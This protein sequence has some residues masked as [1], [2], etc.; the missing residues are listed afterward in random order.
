MGLSDVNLHFYSADER[1]KKINFFNF[2][3]VEYGKLKD[4]V[5]T[6]VTACVKDDILLKDMAG[7]ITKLLLIQAYH[8]GDQRVDISDIS[9]F[10]WRVTKC[11]PERLNETFI[12]WNDFHSNFTDF[13]QSRSDPS[14]LCG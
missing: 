7:Q 4:C 9:L 6:H 5:T 2:F 11:K 8:C 3:S 13:V 10:L 12:C 1:K 14:T